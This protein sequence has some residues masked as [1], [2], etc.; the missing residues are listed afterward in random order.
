VGWLPLRSSDAK[1]SYEVL[2]SRSKKKMNA[3][4][5]DRYDNALAIKSTYLEM[6]RATSSGFPMICVL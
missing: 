5:K 4:D 3:I 2:W 1:I 6:I